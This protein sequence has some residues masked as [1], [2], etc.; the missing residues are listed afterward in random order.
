MTP[1]VEHSQEEPSNMLNFHWETFRKH[2]E[3]EHSLTGHLAQ[4]ANFSKLTVANIAMFRT[5]HLAHF[6]HKAR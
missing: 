1:C 2:W 3:R 4:K 6:P 5:L